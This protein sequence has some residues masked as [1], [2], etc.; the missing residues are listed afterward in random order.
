VSN[1]GAIDAP[2]LALGRVELR[3]ASY[4]DLKK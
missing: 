4:F 3:G 1:N 2:R